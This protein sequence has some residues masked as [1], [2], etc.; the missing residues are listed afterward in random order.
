V[1]VV[2]CLILI[3]ILILTVIGIL[4]SVL[5]SRTCL[6]SYMLA[7]IA[8]GTQGSTL[9]NLAFAVSLLGWFGMNINLFGDALARLAGAL[10]GYAGPVWPVELVAGLLMSFTTLVGLRAI[11]AL[12]V[13][14]VP[15]LGIVCLVMLRKSLEVG[16]LSDILARARTVHLP[17]VGS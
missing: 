11:N 5:G 7:R 1:I 16:S 3:L 4:T 10:W 8:F 2:G 6:S 9:L 12:A 15:I 17:E 13:V 14:I